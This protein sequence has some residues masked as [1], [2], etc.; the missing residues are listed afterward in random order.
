MKY[1]YEII[2]D[3]LQILL[4]Y[5]GWKVSKLDVFERKKTILD[6]KNEVG[7]ILNEVNGMLKGICH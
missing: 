5:S 3:G 2:S 7:T 6:A 4:Q 1:S